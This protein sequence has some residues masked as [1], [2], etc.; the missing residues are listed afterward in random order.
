MH[1]NPSKFQSI[2]LPLCFA[3]W[4]A[5][6]SSSASIIEIDVS[7]DVW[8]T[9]RFSFAGSPTPGGGLN[10]DELRVGGWGDEY[11]SLLQF[12]L[13]SISRPVTSATLQMYHVG[14]P[15]SRHSPVSMVL[16]RVTSD[17]DWTTKPLDSGTRDN[18]RLWWDDRPTFVPSVPSIAAPAVMSPWLVDI[19]GIVNGQI[20]GAYDNYGVQLRPTSTVAAFNYFA[21]SEHVTEEWR[22]KLVLETGVSAPKEVE[23]V[24]SPYVFNSVSTPTPKDEKGVV[25]VTHGYNSGATAEDGWVAKLAEGIASNTGDAINW[26]VYTL[27][28]SGLSAALPIISESGFVRFPS[29]VVP[30]AIAVGAKLGELI[31]A[32]GYDYAHL[33]GHSAGSW[34]VQSAASQI[35][36]GSPSTAIHSTFLDAYV[37]PIYPASII[38]VNGVKV[39][40]LG[41][42]SDWADHY[43]NEPDLLG[44]SYVLDNTFNVEVSEATPANGIS[45]HGYPYEWY[46]DTIDDPVGLSPSWGFGLTRENTGSVPSHGD[47]P[48]GFCIALNSSDCNGFKARVESLKEKTFDLGATLLEKSVSGILDIITIP[49]V[50]YGLTTGSPVW[51]V[52]EVD[53]TEELTGVSLDVLFD[54]PS[55]AE[56]LLAVYWDDVVL[57]TLDQRL[58]TSVEDWFLIIPDGLQGIGSHSLAFRLDNYGDDAAS[59]KIR[60]LVGV[61]SIGTVS[62]PATFGLLVISLLAIGFQQRKRNRSRLT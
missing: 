32:E 7:R 40:S 28:W 37:S 3:L 54:G 12:D 53:L 27:D 9:S 57:G 51:G 13:S 31:A 58:V 20:S 55:T 23:R 5:P 50:E 14:S 29:H 16:D 18:D 44:T 1:A 43:F 11:R 8:T 33:I 6:N 30:N 59:V 48:R 41:S 61:S 35:E 62:E 24:E 47:Y 4:A 60:S 19:T 49:E 10:N 52:F 42:T 56:G 46:T 22:P 45:G 39:G 34:L 36:A 38:R 17:W 25:V 21:S 15:D 26:D 2:L